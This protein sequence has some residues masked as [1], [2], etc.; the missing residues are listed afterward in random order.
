MGGSDS[1]PKYKIKD[2]WF[3]IEYQHRGSPHLHGLLWLQDAPDVSNIVNASQEEMTKVVQYFDKLISTIHPN[4]NEAPVPTHPCRKKLSEVVNFE[5]DLAQLLNRVQ[6]HTVCTP[7]YCLKKENPPTCRFNFPAPM[8]ESSDLD[9]TDKNNIKLVT[10]RNDSRLNKYNAYMIT[11]WRG[12]L[13]VSPVLSMKALINYLAKYVSKSETRSQKLINLMKAIISDSDQNKPARH[14]IQRMFI[15]TCSERDYSAQETCHILMGLKLYS[16]GDRK[17]LSI[18]FNEGV[19]SQQIKKD[20]TPK[21]L[22]LLDQY[23]QRK[24]KDKEMLCLWNMVKFHKVTNP[25]KFN[26]I[27]VYPSVKLKTSK[28][29]NEAFYKQQYL[30][31]VPWRNEETLQ[32][33]KSWEEVYNNNLPL[34]KHSQDNIMCMSGEPDEDN[35][36]DDYEQEVLAREQWMAVSNMRP[37]QETQEVLLGFR[38]I[39]LDKDWHSATAKYEDLGGIPYLQRFLNNA[40]QDSPKNTKTNQQCQFALTTEQLK[41]VELAQLQ[42]LNLK[43]QNK[44]PVPSK[45]LKIPKKVIVQGKAGTGKSVIVS[46]IVRLVE[47]ELGQGSIVVMGP[48]GVSAVNVSGCT[49]Q[50]KLKINSR[51]KKNETDEL[52]PLKGQAAHEFTQA[53]E[54]VKF[55]ICDEFSIIGCSL[56]SKVDK[57]LRQAAGNFD[58][59]FGGMNIY[60]FGDIKQL[61]PVADCA[62]YSTN[63]QSV[64]TIRGKQMY[65]DMDATFILTKIHRQNDAKFLQALN[66]ISEGKVTIEDYNLLSTRF[67][68]VLSSHEREQFRNALHLYPIL[69]QVHRY[70]KDCLETL[71]NME[72]KEPVPVACVTA[73]H[74]NT[75]ASKGTISNAG[76]L[77]PVLHL[78][79]GA[80]IMLRINLW[81]EKGLVNGAMGEIEEIIYNENAHS[82]H[83]PPLVLICKFPSYKGPYLDPIKKTVPIIPLTR[84]WMDANGVTC[85]RE[86]FPITLASSTTIHKSQGLTLTNAFV[87]I[88]EKEMSP[89]LTYVAFSRVKSLSGLNLAPFNYKRF[90][91]LS[92]SLAIHRR[93]AWEQ[94]LQNI[95]L[96]TF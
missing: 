95:Q 26:I 84:S 65:D 24:G 5:E 53:F 39:D 83:D 56:L 29:D 31:F 22:S 59:D 70:N 64:Q 33:D 71:Q 7:G 75:A 41:I 78:A 60:F 23:K 18:N 8:Q 96:D 17:L 66:N 27:M 9:L 54:N 72:T 13:D 89:G 15:R 85:S 10:A 73:K 87:D 46:E 38:Q 47:A 90:K 3:R 40:K 48:T 69:H 94:H 32:G 82:S 50:S 74:S 88:G 35:E 45:N 57:R 43:S 67:T 11:T 61:S 12:N 34:I 81:T 4:I 86:Q 91:S 77:E 63:R 92:K 16:R 68:Y 93:L 79:E 55:V 58:E 51:D 37:N 2:F 76:G 21:T 42:L 30:L 19:Q 49:I 14:A 44:L 25:D 20:G 62:S 80:K 52:I 1:N 36:Y 6:R 28:Q